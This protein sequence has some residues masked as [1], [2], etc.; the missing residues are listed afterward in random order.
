LIFYL[1][2]LLISVWLIGVA[3]NN[4]HHKRTLLICEYI[5]RGALDEISQRRQ[6]DGEQPQ[7][8]FLPCTISNQ[9]LHH[10]SVSS[11]SMVS[12]LMKSK[13]KSS[14]KEEKDK[15]E[16]KREEAEAKERRQKRITANSELKEMSLILKR[17]KRF[18]EEEHEEGSKDKKHKQQQKHFCKTFDRYLQF[19]TNHF[20]NPGTYPIMLITDVIYSLFVDN[21]LLIMITI[22]LMIDSENPKYEILLKYLIL[23]TNKLI[24]EI[25][26]SK[27]MISTRMKLKSL[28][29]S[30]SSSSSKPK[31]KHKTKAKTK[32]KNHNKNHNNLINHDQFR[33]TML[34]KILNVIASLY[35]TDD[36]SFF[37]SLAQLS[38][39]CLFIPYH[40]TCVM[41]VCIIIA[42]IRL[43]IMRTLLFFSFVNLFVLF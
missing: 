12:T 1:V 35:S 22:M 14:K 20:Q 39:R 17:F 4:S 6:P 21:I 34:N 40:W 9:T 18:Q 28:S 13:S 5:I 31:R 23:G 30:S 38:P 27:C 10:P 36:S 16:G 43:I 7:R 3:E 2:D 29:S 24:R 11:A 42:I 19:N 26:K 32:N 37:S 41:I 15:K 33:F 8:Q 25:F